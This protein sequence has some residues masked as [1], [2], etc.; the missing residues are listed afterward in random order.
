M[1]EETGIDR[2]LRDAPRKAVKVFG[3][4]L[5]KTGTKTLRVALRR[6]GHRTL[7][8]DRTLIAAGLAGET[9]PLIAAMD[10]F[11][12]AEDWPWPLVWRQMDAHYGERARFILTRRSSPEVWLESIRKWSLRT[13]PSSRLRER[14]YGYNY[15]HGAEGAYL[16]F[17]RRHIDSVREAF[18]SS[19]QRLLEICFEEG[20]GY[21]EICAFLGE[22]LP[23]RPLLHRNAAARNDDDPAYAAENARRAEAQRRRLAAGR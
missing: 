18:H 7:R 16:D 3:I 12:C 9:A 4:G 22:E 20:D 17:Y 5:N 6:T 14:I 15:P 1:A 23:T 8:P 19:P 11:D 10:R 13:P 2:S 21:P